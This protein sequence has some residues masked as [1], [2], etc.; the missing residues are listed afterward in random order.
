MKDELKIPFGQAEDGTIVTPDEADRAGAYS[1]PRCTAPLV[2]R[3]GAVRRRHFAHRVETS[4]DGESVLHHVAKMFVAE[5]A[6]SVLAGNGR[7]TMCCT[8]DDC[9]SPY[10]VPLPAS[11]FDAVSVEA[12]LPSGRIIDVL[13]SLSGAPALA[14]E[15]RVCHAVDAEKAGALDVPWIE[16]EGRAAAA[17]PTRWT[18]LAHELRT[19]RCRKCSELRRVQ[20]DVRN[21]WVLRCLRASGLRAVP[22]G[23]SADP[24]ICWKCSARTLLYSWDAPGWSGEAPPDPRPPTVRWR[25]SSVVEHHYWANTCH[26]CN[27]LQGDFYRPRLIARASAEIDGEVRSRLARRVRS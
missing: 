11:R 25:Y 15:V 22:F 5:A 17:V 4:C 7:V 10:E 14:V 2:F 19:R 9:R 12:R 18:A 26:N 23:Y 20:D 6:R 13:L 24:A 21:E 3:D 8:C 16:L 27:A 1:C